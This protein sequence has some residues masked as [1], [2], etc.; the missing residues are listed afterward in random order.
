MRQSCCEELKVAIADHPDKLLSAL[1]N[2]RKP[3][4]PC[5]LFGKK[6][7][8]VKYT[9]QSFARLEQTDGEGN[10]ALHLARSTTGKR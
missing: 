9:E 7:K 3:H 6:N 5:P 4:S 10:N 1:S 2:K 8:S